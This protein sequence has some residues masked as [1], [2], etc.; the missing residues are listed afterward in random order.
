MAA[1]Q[2]PVVQSALLRNELVRLRKDKDL[3]QEQVAGSLE[4]ST[5]KIIRIEG[6][7]SS[8]SKTD[9]QALLLQ[10]GVTSQSRIDRL[11]ELARGGRE[12][13]WWNAYKG[14]VSDA[15]IRFIGYEAGAAFIREY[16]SSVV[17]GGLQT[18]EYAQVL[19]IGQLGDI[20]VTRTAKLRLQ[21]Q[22]EMAKRAEPPWRY[23]IVDEAVIR[24]HV[25]IAVDP[26]IM[27]T[28]LRQI[29]DTVEENERVSMRVIPFSAGA[30]LGLYGPFTLLEFD[31]PLSDVLYLEGGRAPS[32]LAT[33][34][35]P[36]VGEYR[37]AYETLLDLALPEDQSVELIR[38]VADEL[39]R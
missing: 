16:Q 31:G 39:S 11:V 23:S 29:A 12:S 25:G 36:R 30:H 34:E 27:P 1:G 32:V 5:S 28:Q 8:I 10:Y 6:G 38:K 26:T 33:A 4:W 2:G 3:T 37:A 20:D 18:A 17:P 13:A 19:N 9:L 14:D 21:R 35:D 7:K 24:R 15:Y 22:A